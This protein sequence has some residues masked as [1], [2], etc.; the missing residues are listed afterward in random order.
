MYQWYPYDEINPDAV[1]PCDHTVVAQFLRRRGRTVDAPAR[2]Y[3]E[4]A[5]EESLSFWQV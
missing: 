2:R 4:Q 3:L 1:Y 5:R